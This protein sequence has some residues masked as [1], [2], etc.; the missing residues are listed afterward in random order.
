MSP[1]FV[2]CS[3]KNSV[4]ITTVFEAQSAIHEHKSIFCAGYIA[5]LHVH[6]AAKGIVVSALLHLMKRLVNDQRGLLSL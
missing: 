1:N 4:Q 2:I 5:V 3:T 6:T